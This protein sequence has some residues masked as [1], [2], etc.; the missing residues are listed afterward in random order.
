V[1]Q[2][3]LNVEKKKTCKRIKV[4]KFKKCGKLHVVKHKNRVCK[5]QKCCGHKKFCLE[6]RCKT[7]MLKCKQMKKMC[8]N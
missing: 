1:K 2:N 7:K 3:K 5:V 4:S 6:G 8:C